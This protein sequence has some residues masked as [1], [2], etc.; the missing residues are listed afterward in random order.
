MYN[1]LLSVCLSVCIF[2]TVSKQLELDSERVQN[3]INK[4][5]NCYEGSS[6]Q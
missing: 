5:K 3:A 1:W 6:E 2:I 4:D